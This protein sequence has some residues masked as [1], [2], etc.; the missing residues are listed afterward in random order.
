MAY[1]P[2][3]Y[4]ID[5]AQRNNLSDD[6]KISLEKIQQTYLPLERAPYLAEYRVNNFITDDDYET[7]TGIPYCFG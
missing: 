5:F 6:Q 3:R 4:Y 2:S 7:M 1:D